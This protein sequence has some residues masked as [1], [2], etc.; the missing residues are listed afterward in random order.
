MFSVQSGSPS[1]IKMKTIKDTFSHYGVVTFVFYRAGDH[2]GFV[3][4]KPSEDAKNVF[5]KVLSI[6]DCKIH[7]FH[8]FNH[9]GSDPVPYQ[10]FIESHNLPVCWEKFILIKNLFKKFEEVNGVFFLGRM[11]GGEQKVVVSFQDSSVVKQLV[12][13]KQRILYADHELMEVSKTT[14]KW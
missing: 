13:T 1:S 2:F 9:L 4:L 6:S 7:T 8:G 3:E 10:I 5:N 11:P 14:I 12:R